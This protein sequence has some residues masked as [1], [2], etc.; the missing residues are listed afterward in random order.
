MKRVQI[1]E[2]ACCG[3]R[4]TAELVSRLREAFDSEAEV[5]S[6]DLGSATGNVQIP[7]SLLLRM[8]DA[9]AAALPALV[10]DGVILA[11]GQLPDVTEAV[12][13]VRTGE[14][15]RRVLSM[16]GRRGCC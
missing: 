11:E 7:T 8:Q 4:L 16:E 1:F 3:S 6:C 14:P 13:L 15:S 9:G 2:R 5:T 12:E 10:V